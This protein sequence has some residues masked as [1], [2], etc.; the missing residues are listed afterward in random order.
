MLHIYITKFLP[1]NGHEKA[2]VDYYIRHALSLIS[3]MIIVGD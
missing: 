2:E 1:V 3:E